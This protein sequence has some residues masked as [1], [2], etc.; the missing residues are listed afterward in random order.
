MDLERCFCEVKEFSE[1]AKY[2]VICFVIYPQEII[3]GVARFLV[4]IL[5]VDIY[6]W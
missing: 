1:A 2:F 4:T 6:F 5:S 3:L